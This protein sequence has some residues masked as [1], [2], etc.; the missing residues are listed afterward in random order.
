MSYENLDKIP[1]KFGKVSGGFYCNNNNLESLEGCPYYVGG[2][3]DCYHNKLTSLVGSPQEIGNSF[4]CAYNNLTSLEGMPLE[5]GDNFNCRNNQL[6]EL[7]SISN[8]EGYIYCDMGTDISKFSGFCK[9]IK[10]SIPQT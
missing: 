8:I 7:N 6:K 5:I 4:N 9:A 1:F 2:K 3:F 10:R